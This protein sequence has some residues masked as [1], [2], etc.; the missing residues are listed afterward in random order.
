MVEKTSRFC[1]ENGK[2][3]G[4]E[5]TKKKPYPKAQNVVTALK[6]RYIKDS[7]KIIKMQTFWP[8]PPFGRHEYRN[9]NK[10]T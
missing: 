3:R 9:N 6:T 1:S 5:R 10:S 4:S 8:R 2:I 7:E